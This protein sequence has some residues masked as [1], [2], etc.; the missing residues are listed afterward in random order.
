[1]VQRR[2]LGRGLG[3]LIPGAEEPTRGPQ[4]L[5]LSDIAANPTQPRKRF[6]QTAL[7]EL[8]ATIRTHGVLAPVV[9][10]RSDEGYQVIAGER[11]VRAAK[12]AG[13]SHIPAIVREA[14]DGQALEMALVEN[15]QREDLNPVESA[16]A[17]Q[18]L[19]GEFGLSQE[20]VAA[21]VGRDRSTVANALRL[22]RLPRKIRDDVAAGALSEGHAR[23]LLGLERPADQLKARDEVVR[24]HLTVR[25]TEALVRRLR[26][27]HQVALPKRPANPNLG[28][29]ED[30]LRVALGSKVRILRSGR[31]GMLEISFFSDDDLTRLVDLIVGE[32]RVA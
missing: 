10:R 5:P 22:L 1:M 25:A 28:S 2:G 4:E 13:L 15:L 29:L 17:Y 21:R 9:V 32:G 18:R 12:L 24:R 23:A 11:R 30:R 19:V 16:E 7:E 3:A 14:G 6:D 31:G 20:A 27:P 26:S 8:A